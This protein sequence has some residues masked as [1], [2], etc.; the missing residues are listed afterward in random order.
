MLMRERAIKFAT[1]SMRPEQ[2]LRIRQPFGVALFALQNR[3]AAAFL[4]FQLA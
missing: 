2:G 4:S 3:V 1:V